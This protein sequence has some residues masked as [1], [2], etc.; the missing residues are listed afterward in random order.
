MTAWITAGTGTATFTGTASWVGSNSL[1]VRDGSVSG[2]GFNYS[3]SDVP[4]TLT[5]DFTSGTLTGSTDSRDLSVNATLNGTRFFGG[6]PLG[7]LPGRLN[8]VA[9]ANGDV[10][11]F[12]GGGSTSNGNNRVFAGGFSAN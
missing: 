9:G 8:G 12:H 1:F 6:V 2:G 3:V 11:A 4:I 5:A 10:A 7:D